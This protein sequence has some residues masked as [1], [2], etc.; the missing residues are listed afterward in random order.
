MSLT[1]SPG[2]NS[3]NSRNASYPKTVKTDVGPVELRV[4]LVELAVLSRARAGDAQA[5][6]VAP[7]DQSPRPLANQCNCRAVTRWLKIACSP[8]GVP[9]V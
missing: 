9:L 3:G 7:H 4:P 6:S 8:C 5:K 1:S 2:R